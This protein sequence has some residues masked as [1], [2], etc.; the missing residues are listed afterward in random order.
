MKLWQKIARKLRQGISVK[1][2]QK[3]ASARR[4]KAVHNEE[5][6]VTF[7]V[8][9]IFEEEN[10]PF[11][12]KDTKLF[13]SRDDFYNA[14]VEFDW[15]LYI[16]GY[17]QAANILVEYVGQSGLDSDILVFPIAFLFRQHLELRIKSLLMAAREL[18]KQ[19]AS[20]I[21]SHDIRQL[22]A[23]CSPLL[24]RIFGD[25]YSRK[26]DTV[27]QIINQ[28]S[29]I[30]PKSEGF[31]YPVDTKG[32]QSFPDGFDNINLGHMAT[33]LS[34]IAVFLDDLQVEILNRGAKE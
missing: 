24:R 23:D 1:A 8:F 11:P 30:D 4:A 2:A 33:T 7:K 5:F 13:V 27:D 18:L 28:F 17:V 29:K 32:K 31:R 3:T 21:L 12:N 10:V 15:E 16:R 34:G 20:P 26:L 14:F 6:S 25:Q 19:A 9:S 22:W